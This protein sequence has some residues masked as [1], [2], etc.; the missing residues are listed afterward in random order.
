VALGSMM[1]DQ[2]SSL[3]C[4]TDLR[5]IARLALVAAYSRGRRSCSSR[6]RANDVGLASLFI[7][8]MRSSLS[9]R[10]TIRR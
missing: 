4:G 3:L 2:R 1:N 6:E 7:S 8:K 5:L 10:G 9:M